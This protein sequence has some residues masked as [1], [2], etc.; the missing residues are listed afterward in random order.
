[1]NKFK[2]LTLFFVAIPWMQAGADPIDVTLPSPDLVL[3]ERAVKAYLDESYV[4]ALAY[5][6]RA[7]KYGHKE[8]Q[9]RVGTIHYAGLA[10]ES[11]PVL[12]Q[13]WLRLSA[14]HGNPRYRKASDDLYKALTESQQDSA[15]AYYEELKEEYGDLA[16]LQRRDRWSRRQKRE[17]TGSRVG[18]TA[19]QV[20]ISLPGP[21]GRA[22][23][24]TGREYYE[25]LTAYVEEL[26][27]FIGSVEIGDL[28]LIDD[29]PEDTD[30]DV[31]IS[32]EPEDGESENR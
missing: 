6:R 15:N 30:L 18:A 11:N 10:G 28:T 7:A 23:R 8:A 21:G 22:I 16:A 3:V 19:S 13:A 29:E 17:L 31:D 20:Q 26:R 1:M 27:P 32:D 2:W 12:A 9:M 24:V 5:Y 14:A 25:T 4:D